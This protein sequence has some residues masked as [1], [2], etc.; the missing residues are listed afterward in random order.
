MNH[1]L[2]QQMNDFGTLRSSGVAR[3]S[4]PLEGTLGPYVMSAVLPLRDSGCPALLMDASDT[5]A[6]YLVRPCPPAA[7]AIVGLKACLVLNLGLILS[8]SLL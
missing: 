6:G 1:K 7:R 5:E 3:A 4:R 2:I 8:V